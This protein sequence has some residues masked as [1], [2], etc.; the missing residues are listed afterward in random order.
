ML[1]PPR[2]GAQAVPAP[3][4]LMLQWTPQAQF[5][6]YYVAAEKGFYAKHGVNLTI[7]PGGPDRSSIEWVAQGKA[8][9]GTM[10]LTG[11][12]VG[13]NAGI[14]LVN[15]EQ[16]VSSST[17]M[18][19]AWRNLGIKEVANLQGR[20]V[21]LW[22]GDFRAP[23]EALF[24]ANGLKVSVLP[25]NYTINLFLRHGVDACAAMYYN[26]YHV[27]YQAGLDANEVTPFFMGDYGFGPPEDGIYCL[28]STLRT[29]PTVCAA[30]A[31]ASLEGWVYARDHRDE[32]L[33]ITMKHVNE[34]NLPTN[35]AH[36]KWMLEKMLEVIFPPDGKAW[37][38]GRLS[39]GNYDR[40]VKLLKDQALIKTAP[41][42]AEFCPEVARGAP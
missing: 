15:I 41:P 1:M 31:E 23:F 39:Q 19:V 4:T 20:R 36:M 9:F 38:V 7:L 26:E 35:R 2:A 18:L 11:A 22:G 28:D 34:A 40:T 3:A 17:L 27:I 16:V 8:Q 25:Q 6:G 32:A 13:R 5:A 21:S 12:L 24:S 30:V 42:Y 29:S 14:P 10:F 33:D 37:Q